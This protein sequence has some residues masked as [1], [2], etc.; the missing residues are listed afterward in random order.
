MSEFLL[1][2]FEASGYSFQMS[3][4]VLYAS[5]ILPHGS[6]LRL[7]PLWVMVSFHLRVLQHS[8]RTCPLLNYSHI[9]CPPIPS[10]VLYRVEQSDFLTR[11][12]TR[13]G[14]GLHFCCEA[15][16]GR[17]DIIFFGFGLGFDSCGSDSC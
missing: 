3:K 5:I 9:H 13:V 7:E 17:I 2:K 15:G 6:R 14:L 12:E 16:F 1:H 10:M 11:P 8:Y 4:N